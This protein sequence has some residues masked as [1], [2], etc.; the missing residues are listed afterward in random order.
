[1][2][3]EKRNLIKMKSNVCHYCISTAD[4]VSRRYKYVNKRTIFNQIDYTFMCIPS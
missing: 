3:Y 2:N 4:Q 1:M